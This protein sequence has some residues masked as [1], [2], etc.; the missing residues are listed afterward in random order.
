MIDFTLFQLKDLEG[1]ESMSNFPNLEN[2]MIMNMQCPTRHML[3]LKRDNKMVSIVGVNTR[4][5]GVGEL[6]TIRGKLVENFKFEFFKAIK[7]LVDDY[8]T[9]YLQFHRLEMCV[10]KDDNKLNKWARTLGFE[11]EGV[12]KK[13]GYDKK[14]YNLYAKVV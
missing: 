5:A 12:M 7:H 3:S 10:Y 9:N 8:A 2:T 11:F 4:C 6:W 13:Y 1:F 14:D